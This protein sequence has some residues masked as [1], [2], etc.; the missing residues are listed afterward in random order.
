MAAAALKSFPLPLT[1]TSAPL[2]AALPETC[3]NVAW[4]KSVLDGYPGEPGYSRRTRFLVLVGA[5]VVGWVPF[6][7]AY[8]AWG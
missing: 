5:V 6:V 4:D 7:A 1:D 8:A 3:R 2:D